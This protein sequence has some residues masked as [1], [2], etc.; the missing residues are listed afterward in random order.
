MNDNALVRIAQEMQHA[1]NGWRHGATVDAFAAERRE[2]LTAWDELRARTRDEGEAVALMSAANSGPNR[3]HQYRTVSWQ[4]SMPR[5]DSRS[6]TCR[7]DSGNRTYIITASRMI[8]GELL[9][10]RKR[11]CIPER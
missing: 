6:S 3:F 2:V 5:S 11:F 7:S 4:M 10:Y 8:S 9:K 1:V